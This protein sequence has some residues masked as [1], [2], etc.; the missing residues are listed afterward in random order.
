[1]HLDGAM[2]GS[3]RH[4]AYN[5]HHNNTDNPPWMSPATAPPPE[6]PRQYKQVYMPRQGYVEMGARDGGAGSM[7]ADGGSSHGGALV[8]APQTQ[9]VPIRYLEA[10][11]VPTYSCVLGMALGDLAIYPT[12]LQFTAKMCEPEAP[13]PLESIDEVSS[14][15][16]V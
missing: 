3:Q 9:T 14:R 2:F 13:V 1:V 15:F 11:V 7:I 12:Y 8:P 6:Q 16:R 4:S 10:T 5:P